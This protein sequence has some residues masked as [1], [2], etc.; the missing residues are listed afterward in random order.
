MIVVESKKELRELIKQR[1]DEQGPNCDLNDIDVSRVTDMSYLFFES[2]FNGDISRWDVSNVT[3][4]SWMFSESVFD[5]DISQWDTSNVESMWYMFFGSVF[6]GDLSKWNVSK[7][8]DMYGMFA[9]SVFNG[10][11]SKWDV[12]K[13]EDMNEMFL[14][15]LLEASG[16][17]P[18][19]Y[20]SSFNAIHGESHRRCITH[21]G[22]CFGSGI[23][24]NATLRCCHCHIFEIG[25]AAK[26]HLIHGGGG[27]DGHGVTIILF[28][29]LILTA[30]EANFFSA[31]IVGRCV[32]RISLLKRERE[33]TR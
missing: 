30:I 21:P 13:V 20:R 23:K 31:A 19:W 6:N 29:V 32:G 17:E 33:R 3:N 18:E 28:G 8:K 12:S 27:S 9:H 15:S 26:H 4:M 16:N 11:I 2:S 14:C 10:D 24:C 7:V 22:E 5:G 25:T 1:I